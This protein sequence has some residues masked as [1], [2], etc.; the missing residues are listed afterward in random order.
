MFAH[1]LLSRAPPV[2]RVVQVQSA[3]QTH[4]RS[5]FIQTAPTPNANSLKFSPG[6]AVVGSANTTIE[7]TSARAAMASPLAKRLFRI[8]GVKE[9]FLGPDFITVTKVDE[10]EWPL[11]KP[12]LYAS[13]MDHYSSGQPVLAQDSGASSAVPADTVIHP[14]DSE[15]VAMIKELLDTRIRPTIQ[16]DGGD[17]EF[18][19]F[20]EETGKVMLKLK[21]AC[22]TCD[23]SV[24]TLK[25]GIENMLMHYVPEV[26]VVEQVFDE[27]E[28]QSQDE[29]KKLEEALKKQ[30]SP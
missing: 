27:L 15:T 1:R 30:M 25:N 10:A 26:T 14:D 24:V 18:M 12:D 4:V 2:V 29:F 21:G 7:F 19:G 22:R 6:V 5:L 17:V 28:Q 3:Q 20:N 23:S 16:D 8:D 13:I 11:L 9:V